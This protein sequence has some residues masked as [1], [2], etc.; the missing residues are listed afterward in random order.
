MDIHRCSPRHRRGQEQGIRSPVC[1][2]DGE[3]ARQRGEVKSLRQRGSPLSIH[4]IRLSL[5]EG[6]TARP[7][8]RPV[9]R[10]A[11][12]WFRTRSAASKMQV[13]NTPPLSIHTVD[14]AALR[15]GT[16]PAQGFAALL[17]DAAAVVFR[18]FFSADEVAWLVET[19]YGL[20][21]E[22]V[23]GFEGEQYSIG[24]VWYVDLED[25][26]AD[27]YHQEAAD[28]NAFI[29]EH[30]DGIQERIRAFCAAVERAGRV[31][32]R[33]GWAGPGF[34][35]F[36]VG[37]ECSEHG[38]SIHF[39]WEGLPER[40]VDDPDLEAYSFIAMLQKP[41]QGGG[42]R[43]WQHIYHPDRKDEFIP[44]LAAPPDGPSVLIDY[45][46]GDLVAINSRWMHQIQP[47]SGEHDRV[48]LTFHIVRQ[49]SDWLIWF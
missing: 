12:D 13:M 2:G 29:E 41:D 35:I 9:P 27:V 24:R 33:P 40:A 3:G 46:P 17:G 19:I 48:T 20:E 47:F 8:A 21:E 23:E 31:Q 44:E 14:A 16:L 15:D 28:T 38:G 37:N 42:L 11:L 6:L 30:F 32:L 22:W 43:V 18:D 49:G 1:R 36:P 26:I 4:T 39:D 25:G 7:D 45:R 34:V 10:S 5:V